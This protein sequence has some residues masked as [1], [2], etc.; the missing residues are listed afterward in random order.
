MRLGSVFQF[1]LTQYFADVPNLD[2]RAFAP[3]TYI[4]ADVRGSTDD[5]YLYNHYF[6][7]FS[8]SLP[9]ISSFLF[10]QQ[11]TAI[12]ETMVK[13]LLPAGYDVLTIDE[14]WYV[15]VCSFTEEPHA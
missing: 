4:C 3:R 2:P 12:A 8:F 9:F 5:S 11:A 15:I 1:S 10:S 14:F 13:Y 7:F 6:F